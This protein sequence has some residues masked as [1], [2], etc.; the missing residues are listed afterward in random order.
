MTEDASI[1]KWYEEELRKRGLSEADVALRTQKRFFGSKTPSPHPDDVSSVR[2]A[3]RVMRALGYRTTSAASIRPVHVE[4]VAMIAL[5]P[6]G[7]NFARCIPLKDIRVII[8]TSLDI[9]NQLVIT[10]KG[11]ARCDASRTFTLTRRPTTKAIL[12]TKG[13]DSVLRPKEYV[14]PHML[15][16]VLRMLVF[17]RKDM[18]RSN[19]KLMAQF[20]TIPNVRDA[21]I[22]M[23]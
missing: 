16:N 3:L 10:I 19:V 23:L 9:N 18:R 7:A 12:T 15:L 11:E 17:R 13:Y 4:I 5:Y 8:S 2:D 1:K 21:E 6:D 14:T 22:R 20:V